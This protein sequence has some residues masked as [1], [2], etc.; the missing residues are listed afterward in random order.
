MGSLN[1]W[2]VSD[3]ELLFVIDEQVVPT[4]GYAETKDIALA[5]GVTGKYP[6]QPTAIRLSWMAKFGL[7]ERH[8]EHTY[9]WR[10]TRAGRG[11]KDGE[12]DPGQLE[13]FR[14]MEPARIVSVTHELTRRFARAA[15]PAA[16]M[17]RR[18]WQRGTMP[19]RAK[20]KKP[21]RE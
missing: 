6:A 20:P 14:Q 3:R 17:M 10:L 13:M 11:L 8:R 12:L 16:H 21:E 1:L 7:I 4:I 18:E 15:K 19:P 5:L 9:L 2:D